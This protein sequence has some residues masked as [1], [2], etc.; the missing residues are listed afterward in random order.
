MCVY[1]EE[2]RR[3]PTAQYEMPKMSKMRRLC[4]LCWMPVYGLST[5]MSRANI[6]G[7]AV[8]GARKAASACWKDFL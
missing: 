4:D 8:T 5:K 2:Y 1:R 7:A 6:F 3:G